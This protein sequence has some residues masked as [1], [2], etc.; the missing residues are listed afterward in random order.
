M[1][2]TILVIGGGQA[3]AQAVDTVRR[4]GFTGRLVLISEEPDLPYQRPPLSKAF[5]A[6][7]MPAERLL[8]KHRP[9]YD[10]HRI[11]LKLDARAVRI[12]PAAHRVTLAS[13]E[14]IAYDR[15]L[16]C[17]GALAR[18]LTCPG[19][20]LPGVHYLRSTADAIGIQAGLKTGGHV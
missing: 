2:E 1:L 18:R 4:E 11:E 19:A 6:G 9:F 7:Q 14:Q 10:E 15:L 13:G 12:E 5:L 16:L 3:C 20:D 17:I 8:F